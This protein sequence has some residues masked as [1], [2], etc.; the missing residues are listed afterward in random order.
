LD[1]AKLLQMNVSKLCD[2]YLREVVQREQERRWREE[3][4]EF[5]EAYNATIESEGLPLQQW[6]TF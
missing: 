5:V 6:A 3:H 4:M 2:S 1:A